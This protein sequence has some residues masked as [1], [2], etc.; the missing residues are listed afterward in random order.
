M[1]FGSRALALVLACGGLAAA[2]LVVAA[3]LPAL[4]RDGPPAAVTGGFGE[5][6]CYACHFDGEPNGG[7]GALA[8]RGI[9]ERFEPGETYRIEVVLTRP[10]MGV[11]G[12]QLSAREAGGGAQA[13]TLAPAPGEEARLGSLTAREIHYIQHVLE[14]IHLVAPDTAR[15]AVLWTA[16]RAGV[17]VTFNAAAVAGD[18]D[19]SQFG[20]HVHTAK[21][22]SVPAGH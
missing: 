18:D 9:P 19:E 21:A 5:D 10:G 11:G 22:R 3:G 4:F 20:D 15:W 1:I 2:P 13:G 8:I 6:S 17:P 7:R 12:F 14:G 16:P